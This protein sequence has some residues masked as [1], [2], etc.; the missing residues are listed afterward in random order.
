VNK[1]TDE[2]M[3]AAGYERMPD[4]T[5]GPVQFTGCWWKPSADKKDAGHDVPSGPPVKFTLALLRLDPERR[6]I[7]DVCNQCGAM[8]GDI[9][10]HRAWHRE[11][12]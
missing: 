1:R 11:Q 12:P 5:T 6:P 3:L 10:T 2:E 8:V 7:A 4:I 9:N